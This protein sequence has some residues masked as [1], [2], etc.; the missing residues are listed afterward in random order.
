[1]LR[2]TFLS[3]S[4]V[5]AI[6]A[7]SL[8]AAEPI[9]V[10]CIGDSI[11]AGAGIRDRKMHYP[12]QLGRLLG[13]GY[14]VINCGNSGSTLLK[15]GDRPFWNQGEW[16]KALDFNPNIV[17]IKLGTN[18][19]KPQNWKKKA[20]F[21]ADFKDMIAQ[22]RKLP[23]KPKIFICKPVPVFQTRW[24]I[25]EKVVSGE[26]IPIVEQVAKDCKLPVI[27]LHKALSGKKEMFPDGIHPNGAGAGVMA[28]VIAKAITGKSAGG[29]ACPSCGA[30]SSFFN[31]KD[32]NGWTAK[33]H[34]KAPSRW[35][36][37]TAKVD[38]KNPKLLIVVP[39][40]NE[41]VN[42]P[43]GHGKSL[44]FYSG[45]KHGDG[46]ITLELM[47]PKGSNSG[48]YL[49]GEYEIQVLDSFGKKKMR[50]SDMG[51][52][53]GATPPKTNACKAPGQWQRYEIH[54]K[55]PKFDDKG[56]KT[57]NAQIVKVL[58]NGTLIQEN[59]ELKGP[60]PGGVNGK[61]KAMGP[62]MFQGN[63]G[64]VAYRNIKIKPLK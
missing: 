19:S 55:A 45:K 3:V 41:M 6:F 23:A 53:Y 7:G 17:V 44:D 4:L 27:D 22:L 31:G 25:S 51:A 48:I 9:R 52:V 14:K 34:R 11:T 28:A 39:G 29:C 24:G 35:S 37:G 5:L 16:K 21:A 46:I 42:T 54:F 57:A 8:A 12:N 36:V 32:L 60:T 59:I 62:L 20:Q 56:K 43:A 63:H 18:D 1:M 30:K 47:V 15:K 10:A 2:R 38:P 26:V 64:P 49:Q 33:P 61:E 13:D 40:G 58:L 50:M